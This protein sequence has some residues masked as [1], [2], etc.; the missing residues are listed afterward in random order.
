VKILTE[1]RIKPLNVLLH[2]I[3]GVGKTTLGQSAPAP[4]FITAEELDEF[5]MPRFEKCK[6][7]ADFEGQLDYLL[8][9]DHNYKTLVIDTIDSIETLLHRKIAGFGSMSTALGGFGKAYEA[10][11]AEFLRIRDRYLVPLRE[12]MNILI[13]AHSEAKKFED[14]S[15]LMTYDVFNLKMHKKAI[16]IFS[17][18]VSC[19]FFYTFHI[20]RTEGKF[21]HSQGHRKIYTS[22]RPNY[23]A[24]NRFNL[25]DEIIIDNKENAFGLIATEI[26]KYYTNN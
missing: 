17:E 9:S 12:R 7:F 25:A 16:P 13:L 18:W 21:A 26:K 2:G 8:K 3:P 19:I 20:E 15:S 6:T 22:A 1:K 10:A 4:I 5:N 11:A 14:C 24:K 23:L